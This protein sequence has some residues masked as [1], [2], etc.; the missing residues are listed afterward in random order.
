MCVCMLVCLHLSVMKE[1]RVYIFPCVCVPCGC[2]LSLIPEG[3]F[4][5]FCAGSAQGGG[6]FLGSCIQM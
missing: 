6:E 4:G 5:V 1:S 2:A 3:L